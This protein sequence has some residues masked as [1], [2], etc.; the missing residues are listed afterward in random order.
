MNDAAARRLAA[1][2]LAF[3]PVG[4][5]AG[6]SHPPMDPAGQ[7]ATR[8]GGLPDRIGLAGATV[9]GAAFAALAGLCRDPALRSDL[10]D[11][12]RLAALGGYRPGGAGHGAVSRL[13][14]SKL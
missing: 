11:R 14:G 3:G 12:L 9:A 4:V 6:G 2:A 7:P 13:P 5:G 10:S 1:L 8:P